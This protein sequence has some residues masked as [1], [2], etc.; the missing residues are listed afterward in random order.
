MK[1]KSDLRIDIILC[2][3]VFGNRLQTS[4]KIARQLGSNYSYVSKVL[5]SLKEEGIIELSE[6]Q[7]DE[8]NKILSLTEKGKTAS[9]LISALKKL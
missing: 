8:K 3:G 9:K 7:I 4:S 1:T 2:F 6:E 5:K